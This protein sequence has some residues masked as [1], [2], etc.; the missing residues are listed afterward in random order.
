M[1]NIGKSIYEVELNRKKLHQPDL[2][3][4]KLNYSYW[5]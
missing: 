5:D 1:K 3:K 4:F 2:S